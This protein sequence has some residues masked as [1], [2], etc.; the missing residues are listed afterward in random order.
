M[1][2]KIRNLQLGYEQLKKKVYEDSFEI[3]KLQSEV[4][5]LGKYNFIRKSTTEN[6]EKMRGGMSG[7]CL[8]GL[9]VE[10]AKI[11][12]LVNYELNLRSPTTAKEIWMKMG[13]EK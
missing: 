3:M 2:K 10:E 5:L 12:N 1:F 13:G 8:F 4:D 6:L 9:T 7:I 11:R